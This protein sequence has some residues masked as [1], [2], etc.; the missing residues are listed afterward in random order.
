MGSEEVS[1]PSDAVPVLVSEG[2]WSA[3]A[4]PV[5]SAAALGLLVSVPPDCCVGVTDADAVDRGV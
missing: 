3:L 5:G 1:A 4:D 2:S